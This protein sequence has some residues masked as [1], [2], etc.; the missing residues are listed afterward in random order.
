MIRITIGQDFSWM[1]STLSGAICAVVGGLVLAKYQRRMDRRDIIIKMVKSLAAEIKVNLSLFSIKTGYNASIFLGLSSEA[2]ADFQSVSLDL[3][4]NV[5]GKLREVYGMIAGC[6][7]FGNFY[8]SQPD[9]AVCPHSPQDLEIAL[10]DAEV[11]LDNWMKT[12]S[13]K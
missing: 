5:A 11:L 10:K 3:P 7:A 12:S 6:K 13:S 4:N 9:R 1:L 2:W 8:L